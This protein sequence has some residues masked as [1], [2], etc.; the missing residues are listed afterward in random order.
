MHS[1]GKD[2]PR[3]LWGSSLA[4]TLDSHWP[5]LWYSKF[6]IKSPRH[7]VANNAPLLTQ[8]GWEVF[9]P[10]II[11]TGICGTIDT[12]TTN[13]LTTHENPYPKNSQ[14]HG[15]PHTNLHHALNT[16]IPQQKKTKKETIPNHTRLIPSPSPPHTHR[17]YAY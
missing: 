7:V 5:M 1:L 16:H 11:T 9:L 15:Y 13:N 2:A 12:Q 17:I 4:T 8:Q 14:T 10:I 6:Y 3:V